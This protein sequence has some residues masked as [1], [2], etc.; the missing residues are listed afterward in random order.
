MSKIL[1]LLVPAIIIYLAIGLFL[2]LKQRTFLYNP[3][4]KSVTQYKTFFMENEGEEISIIVL[5]EG[6]DNAILYFGGNA[7]SMAQS[8]DYIAA[9]FP[10]FTVYLMEYRGYGFSTGE[11]SE[12]ALYSDALK[13]Y[14]LAGKKHQRISVGGRSLGT[15]V[16]TYVA[17]KR[18]VIKLALIT[19]FDSIVAVAQERYPFYPVNM[20]LLDKYDSL[21]RVKEIKAKTFIVIAENDEIISLARSEKLIEAFPKSQVRVEV[22]KGRGHADI[23]SD[24]RYYKIMQ[25]FI[26]EG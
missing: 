15:A 25:D 9:Q 24:E 3:S 16:A 7:E 6:H 19:P 8:A 12:E 11:A 1:L 10:N 21:S 2:Y 13:L 17:A 22:I 5:N 14:D 23:S 4:E 20:L 18:E 26:G